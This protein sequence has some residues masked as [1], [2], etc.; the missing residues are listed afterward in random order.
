MKNEND[1]I[2]DYYQKFFGCEFDYSKFELDKL[3]LT[4]LDKKFLRFQFQYKYD[5]HLAGVKQVDKGNYVNERVPCGY[6]NGT[7]RWNGKVCT[8]C[9]GGAVWSKNWV[10]RFVSVPWEERLVFPCLYEKRQGWSLDNMTPLGSKE[11]D[12]CI[13][14]YTKARNA[15]DLSFDFQSGNFQNVDKL[16][17]ANVEASE[18]DLK[19][20]GQ[21]FIKNFRENPH[22]IDKFLND[23]KKYEVSDIVK[24]QIQPDIKCYVETF[25]LRE[26]KLSDGKLILEWKEINH[27]LYDLAAPNGFP[28]TN[29]GRNIVKLKL[30]SFSIASIPTIL[31]IIPAIQSQDFSSELF[32]NIM[33]SLFYVGWRVAVI[34]VPIYL[35]LYGPLRPAI[36]YFTKD[37]KKTED[38]GRKFAEYVWKK[39]T[40]M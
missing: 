14:S 2:L 18:K 26:Y 31:S 3:A 8:S 1:I 5:V 36:L 22:D 38:D 15:I 35:I 6:C 33:L 11:V 7:G 10:S 32:S 34:F 17:A 21:E 37:K 13:K 19:T 27:N 40:P 4:Y 12:N 25:L 30:I 29:S 24:M 20:V 9:T 28:L 23:N 16:K 39:R